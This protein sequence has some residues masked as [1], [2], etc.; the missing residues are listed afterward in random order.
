M[1][2]VLRMFTILLKT[3]TLSFHS[4]ESS[5]TLDAWSAIALISTG[6]WLIESHM[7][8]GKHHSHICL[9]M[10]LHGRQREPPMLRA[11]AAAV[12]L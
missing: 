11:Y 6:M 10:S 2:G 3:S 5:K 12:V 4:V 1:V 9:A 7:F 8:L